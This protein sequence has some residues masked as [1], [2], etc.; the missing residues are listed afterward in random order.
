MA[1]LSCLFARRTIGTV[2]NIHCGQDPLNDCLRNPLVAQF[3]PQAHQ[4]TRAKLFPVLDPELG[5]RHFI[6]QPHAFQP[7]KL[8]RTNSRGVTTASNGSPGASAES[9]PAPAEQEALIQTITDRVMGVL[10]G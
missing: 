1:Q 9:I 10:S 4:S 5:K 2:R 6:Q 8:R 7:P 3:V